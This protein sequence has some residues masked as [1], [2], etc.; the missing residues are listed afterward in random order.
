MAFKNK[1]LSVLAYANG[2]TLWHYVSADAKADV[3]TSGYFNEVA[4]TLRKGDLV[5]VNAG[6][7]GTADNTIM[8]VSAVSEGAVSIADM[9]AA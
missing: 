9:M 3:A 6:T 2:F 1:D 5:I 8:V 7:E 4:D